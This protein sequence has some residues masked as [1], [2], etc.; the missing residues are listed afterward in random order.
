MTEKNE[1][2]TVLGADCRIKGQIHLDSDAVILGQVQ[3]QIRVGGMLDLA[4]SSVV[5]GLV[6]AGG[7]RL[8]GKAKADVVAE[9]GM[10]LLASAQLSGHL[11]T[12]RLSVVDGAVFEGH[13]VVGPKAI[14]AAGDLLAKVQEDAP[15]QLDESISEETAAEAPRRSSPSIDINTVPRSLDEILQRRRAKS[16]GA[17]MATSGNGNGN[18][19]SHEQA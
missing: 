15:V 13:V 6:V 2:K 3:G 19:H 10:E 18:G 17:A 9:H 14:Q 7:L 16:N 12:T 5:Q 11:Y 1:A 4:E 8:G